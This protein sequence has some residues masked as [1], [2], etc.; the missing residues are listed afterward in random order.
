MSLEQCEAI[1][2]A[3]VLVF[4]QSSPVR[5]DVVVSLQA[6]DKPGQWGL[7]N[8]NKRMFV[9]SRVYGNVGSMCCLRLQDIALA[10]S[11]FQTS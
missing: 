3:Q 4:D 9:A 1:E 5:I 7:T 10:R 11:H 2:C 8:T 6:F